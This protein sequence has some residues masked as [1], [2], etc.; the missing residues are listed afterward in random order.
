MGQGVLLLTIVDKMVS[1]PT[2]VLINS[3]PCDS[4][5]ISRIHKLM[6]SY[7][8]AKTDTL[9]VASRRCMH[10]ACACK[11]NSMLLP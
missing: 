7:F 9:Y 8:H 2:S 10:C 1:M 3:I 6:Q 4:P 5:L 11:I